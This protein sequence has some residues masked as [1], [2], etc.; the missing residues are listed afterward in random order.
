MLITIKICII[1]GNIV[2]IVT[3]FQCGEILEMKQWFENVCAQLS[4][5]PQE[6][7]R[8]LLEFRDSDGAMQSSCQF[9]Q[10]LTSLSPMAQ[11]QAVSILQ[12]TF[13]KEW[14]LNQ[15][16]T[17]KKEAIQN[18][19]LHVLKSFCH[20]S[21]SSNSN[22]ISSVSSPTTRKVMQTYSL[23]WK[24]EWVTASTQ[25]KQVLFHHI[26]D[27]LSSQNSMR[28]AVSL[29][30]EIVIEFSTQGNTCEVGLSLET[31]RLA[32]ASFEND[33]L[34]ETLNASLSIFSQIMT[35]SMRIL[36]ESSSSLSPTTTSRTVSSVDLVGTILLIADASSLVTELLHWDFNQA[37]T[38]QFRSGGR[39][40]REGSGRSSD[41]RVVRECLH[42]PPHWSVGF[43]QHRVTT[44]L[45][46]VYQQLL[47]IINALHHQ[48]HQQWQGSAEKDAVVKA[49][50][51]LRLL[52]LAIASIS[53]NFLV[54]TTDKITF[55]HE[56]LQHVFPHLERL[57]NT[58]TSLE[59]SLSSSSSLSDLYT[60]ECV[61]FSSL[62]L[63]VVDTWDLWLLVALPNAMFSS[64]LQVLSQ[65]TVKMI[66]AVTS[67]AERRLA[68]LLAG[69]GRS[70]GVTGEDDD[71]L[72]EGWRGQALCNLFET[73]SRLVT[74]TSLS[75]DSIS[76]DSRSQINTSNSSNNMCPLTVESFLGA[77]DESHVLVGVCMFASSAASGSSCVLWC[78]KRQRP[79]RRR[80]RRFGFCG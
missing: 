4:S 2:D 30:L 65:F 8:A 13:L 80:R 62:V 77:V 69:Y 17:I 51:Q 35:V 74:D 49:M 9:M 40:G 29:L 16:T 37:D 1:T 63:H 15:M 52:S 46:A 7:T 54:E 66:Q 47:H 48:Q 11:F 32:K 6:A 41:G 44:A 70:G 39:E 55:C 57:V 5:N 50:I 67:A 23:T 78:E 58:N 28:L 71:D 26:Q 60:E 36:G 21:S 59:A 68:V 43:S 45:F 10:D 22:S 38:L 79:E 14:K 24:H 20:S 75:N 27:L 56:L 33:G 3:K 76:M 53:S 18:L 34:D 61:H 64:L 42:L 19:L 72:L 31:H 73:W 25:Q 12:F